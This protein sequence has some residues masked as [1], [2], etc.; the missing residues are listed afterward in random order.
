MALRRR[1]PYLLY[2][3]AGTGTFKAGEHSIRE[4]NYA[5]RQLLLCLSCLGLLESLQFDNDPA[6]RISKAGPVYSDF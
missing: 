2:L 5:S 6:N 4:L 1:D 3:M